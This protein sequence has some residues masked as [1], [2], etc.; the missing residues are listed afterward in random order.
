MPVINFTDS[1]GDFVFDLAMQARLRELVDQT[2]GQ[3]TRINLTFVPTYQL[4]F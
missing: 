4:E 1:A 2:F 3:E